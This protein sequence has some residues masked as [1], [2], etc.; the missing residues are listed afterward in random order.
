V[1]QI[2]EHIETLRFQGGEA[3]LHPHICDILCYAENFSD[4]FSRVLVP[5]NATYMLNDEILL[6]LKNLQYELMVLIDDYG[7]CSKKLTQLVEQLKNNNISHEVRSYNESEQYC[8]GWFDLGL[9]GEIIPG[10][11][12][13]RFE[14]C[15]NRIGCKTVQ[16]GKLWGCGNIASGFLVGRFE[17][18]PYDYVDLRMDQGS[19]IK[20]AKHLGESPF[21]G[22]KFCKG[23]DPERTDRISAAEQMER[24][25]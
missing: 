19:R 11:V 5:T 21:Y 17:S 13:E 23:F 1:L 2:Y 7:V 24:S 6:T 20:E 22:C 25:K 9:T 15:H 10:S 14:K 4:R 18:K 12:N 8:G 16:C 3:F